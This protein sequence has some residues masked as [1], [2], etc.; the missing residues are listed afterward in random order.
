MDDKDFAELQLRATIVPQQARW[1]EPK[2]T[3]WQKLH[4]V[5]D[6]ARQRVAKAYAAM[7]AV[8]KDQNLSVEGKKH[9]R[10]KVVEQALAELKRSTTLEKARAAVARQQQI[11]ADKFGLDEIIRPA[12]DIGMATI[13]AQVRE[14]VSSMRP[15]ERLGFLQKNA[16]DAMVAAA[17]LSAPAFL[18]GLSDSEMLFVKHSI[19]KRIIPAEIAEARVAVAKA[20]ADAEQ[21]WDQAA[22]LITQRGEL[23][24]RRQ[25][26]ELNQ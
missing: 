17:I 3:H 18:S 20:L 11:W 1:P 23:K 13:H 9:A 26:F 2:Y 8:D 25:A 14:R 16:G 4:A 15:E 10:A 24:S 12:D 22:K 19:E 6:E 7:D 5:P 21:G